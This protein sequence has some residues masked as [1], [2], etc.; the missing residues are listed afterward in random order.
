M[1]SFAFSAAVG[2]ALLAGLASSATAQTTLT[3]WNYNALTGPLVPVVGT[4][5]SG[6]YGQGAPAAPLSN[7]VY[8]GT[9]VD[10]GTVI[11]G[12]TFN[13][14]LTVNPPLISTANNSTGVWFSAPTTGMQPGEQVKLSWSQTVGYRSSRFWQVLVST[15]GGT[16]GFSVPSGATGS[17]ISQLVSGYNTGSSSISG[18]ATVNVNST[19]LVDFRTIGGGTT[20]N[21]LSPSVTTTGTF[22]T[23]PLAA[24]S[25]DNISITLP[26]GQGFENNANF[27]FAIVGAFDPSL[28]AVS[29]TT[30]YVSSFAG[31]DST[32]A[33]MGYN[34]SLG[35]GG[36]LR[37]DLVTVSAVPEPTTYAMLGASAL[38]GCS[39][40]WRRR[41]ESR[42]A[43]S[44][45]G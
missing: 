38:I 27:A 21:F 37:L 42:L 26:T 11:T 2:A 39:I 16:T 19:G 17:S 24:G 18:T 25:V 41:R 6:G 4:G 14:A 8:Q 35:S 5:T 10:S 30:G 45:E 28:S 40:A 32:D 34:R 1:R 3:Q 33:V 12:T 9:L 31:T 36:S 13:R 7:V 23:A 22:W 43:D 15:T 20:G 29:G 44:R